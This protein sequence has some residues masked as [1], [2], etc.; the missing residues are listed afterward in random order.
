ML[1]PGGQ[2]IIA[3]LVRHDLDWFHEQ[4]S[5]QWM[6]FEKQGI[7][8]WLDAAGYRTGQYRQ[9]EIEKNLPTVFVL[10]AEKINT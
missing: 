3:D 6:G 8:T 10:T 2:L 4:M 9:I 5:D 7:E 1:E